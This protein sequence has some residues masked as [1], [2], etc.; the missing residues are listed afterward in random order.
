MRHN[1]LVVTTDVNLVNQVMAFVGG[2][3][4]VKEVKTRKEAM[5][6]ALRE[7]PVMCIV[8]DN[9]PELNGYE[10]CGTVKM[11][12]RK[13]HIGF[14]LLGRN[15]N[16]FDDRKA[17][18]VGVDAFFVKPMERIRFVGKLQEFKDRYEMTRKSSNTGG[19]ALNTDNKNVIEINLEDFGDD[20]DN[21]FISTSV[22][23]SQSLQEDSS[24]R[25]H[26]SSEGAI[27][28][29]IEGNGDSD[30]D[31]IAPLATLKP[32]TQNDFGNG[33][34]VQDFIASGDDSNESVSKT[35]ETQKKT[36]GGLLS[37]EKEI[38]EAVYAVIR[39]KT[40]FL[41]EERVERIVVETVAKRLAKALSALSPRILKAVR[42]AVEREVQKQ[43]EPEVA[44]AVS[45]SIKKK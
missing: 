16:Q 10:L 36:S 9:V 14:L 12:Y 7:E 4:N 2:Q 45:D 29:G 35:V 19:N 43:L 38:A 30:S 27:Y 37:D 22:Q 39:E 28:H 33:D 32:E 18:L 24:D 20:D 3:C 34:P 42:A 21:P 44:K 1:V 17:R 41:S 15:I 8:D 6:A 23:F 13:E 5:Q 25:A 40:E 26:G 11:E 31:E